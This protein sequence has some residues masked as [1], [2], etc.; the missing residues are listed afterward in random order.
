MAH[1]H[2]S[3]E[4]CCEQSEDE[5]DDDNENLSGYYCQ[6]SGADEE[7][8]D[9]AD[10]IGQDLVVAFFADA[11]SEDDIDPNA[12]EACAQAVFDEQVAFFSRGSGRAAGV[13]VT[14]HVHPYRPTSELSLDERKKRI[15][16]AKKKSACNACGKMGHWANGAVCEMKG[17]KQHPFAKCNQNTGVQRKQFKPGTVTIK[18]A[19][20][21]ALG[22]SDVCS[23]GAGELRVHE[24]GASKK[25]GD[26]CSGAGKVVVRCI[27]AAESE[28]SVDHGNGADSQSGAHSSGT[29]EVGVRSSGTTELE[30][31]VIRGSGAGSHSRACWVIGD[32]EVDGGEDDGDVPTRVSTS[33]RL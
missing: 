23:S 3:D 16:A 26:H 7:F 11:A 5:S 21:L 27:G 29:G 13:K 30:R 1:V 19:G 8:E 25:S 6:S 10:R 32:T 31:S 4:S 20:L 33:Q 15:D 17:K 2:C 14:K 18:R 22:S 24:V 28:G 9:V 12:A